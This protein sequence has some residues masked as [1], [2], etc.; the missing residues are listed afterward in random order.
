MAT[1]DFDMFSLCLSRRI[2]STIVGY[3]I[4]RHAVHRHDS[5]FRSCDLSQQIPLL[6]IINVRH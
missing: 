2:D 4:K 1:M 3:L 6:G 5:D